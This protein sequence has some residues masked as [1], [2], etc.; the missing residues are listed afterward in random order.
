MGVSLKGAWG[1]IQGRFRAFIQARPRSEVDSKMLEYGSGTIYAGFPSSLA[2]GVGEQ[3]YSNFLASSVH[4]VQSIDTAEHKGH[5]SN[6]MTCL[7]AP[8]STPDVIGPHVHPLRGRT[9]KNI[10][11]SSDRALP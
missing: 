1:L 10:D 4:E 2:F 6:N 8:F 7:T 11:C 5:D 3:S 9:I